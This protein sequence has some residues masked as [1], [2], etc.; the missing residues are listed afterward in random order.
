M[1]RV[2]MVCSQPHRAGVIAN[3]VTRSN[4]VAE[5]LEMDVGWGEPGQWLTA[6]PLWR[7]AS[8]LLGLH[9]CPN[10]SLILA[11]EPLS[12]KG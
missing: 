12:F 7:L 10:G 1:L 4:E 8:G 3:K 11:Q 9:F 2:S 6:N 5:W